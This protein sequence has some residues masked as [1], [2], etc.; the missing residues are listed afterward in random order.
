[1]A[2][3]RPLDE[4]ASFAELAVAFAA[5]RSLEELARLIVRRA[6]ELLAADGAVLA[7]AGSPATA[8]SWTQPG[9]VAAGS[10]RAI[11]DRSSI[12]RSLQ[13]ERMLVLAPAQD[14][15]GS[16]VASLGFRSILSVAI[17]LGERELGVLGV[18]CQRTDAWTDVAL[19]QAELLSAHAALALSACLEQEGLRRS[20]ESRGVIGQAQGILMQRFGLDAERAFVVLTRYSQ[21]G[22]VKLIEVARSVVETG[23][24]PQP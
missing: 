1:M 5:P 23:S 10:L 15:W 7:L 19:R 17:R 16:A 12:L 13:G 3:S 6:A 8:V 18:F 20:A 11:E 2:E 21:T 24:L 4:A 22:N 14:S 9:T